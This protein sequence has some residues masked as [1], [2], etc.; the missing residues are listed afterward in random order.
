MDYSF[1][2]LT[3]K[4]NKVLPLRGLLDFNDENPGF[5]T[6]NFGIG[7]N[8]LEDDAVSENESII[9]S[10]EDDISGYEIQFEK[11]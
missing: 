9:T 10:F 5:L 3:V 8:S 2:D 6:K 11:Y 4:G 7:D 1:D